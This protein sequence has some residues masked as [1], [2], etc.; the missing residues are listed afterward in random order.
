[1]IHIANTYYKDKNGQR[2]PIAEA[3][4]PSKSHARFDSHEVAGRALC[5]E[6]CTPFYIP[7]STYRTLHSLI[8]KDVHGHL[9]CTDVLFL[10][11]IKQKITDKRIGGRYI[12]WLSM[13][14]TI[15]CPL[16]PCI[17]V[18]RTYL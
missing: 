3:M 12:R 13:T 6:L 14:V 17:A 11:C 16:L 9:I 1:M 4:L 5:T 15:L 2:V 18:A 8:L 7:Q 10:F